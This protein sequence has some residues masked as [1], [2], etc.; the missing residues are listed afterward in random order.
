MDIKPIETVYNGYK[1]RSRLEARWAVYFDESEIEYEYEPE[2]FELSD[3]TL[4]LPDFYLPWFKCF[5]EIKPKSISFED[6]EIAKKKLER[7]FET[8]RDCCVMLCKGDPVDSD[9]RVGCNDATDSGGGWCGSEWWKAEFVIGGWFDRH[10]GFENS[11]GKH[12]ISMCLGT[13]E[14]QRER[15]FFTANFNALPNV[16][17][18]MD[19]RTCRGRLEGSKVKARQARFE[20]GETP[21][22]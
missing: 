8:H 2:G 17:Q 9:M 18:M 14:D 21:T 16:E 22:V 6:E 12:W 19:L 13:K 15:S 3:G 20:H 1:F 7:L 11:N 4:Y 5:V 10:D